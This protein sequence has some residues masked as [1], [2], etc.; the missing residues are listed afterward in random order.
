MT[1]NDN[2]LQT[3]LSYAAKGWPVFPVNS[4]KLP[5][6]KDWER[7]ASTDPDQIKKWYSTLMIGGCNFGFTPG[8]AGILVVDID[9]NKKDKEGNEVS[10]EKNWDEFQTKHGK[11][12]TPYRVKT[13]SGGLHL[14]FKAENL[15]SK[16]AFLP[17]VDVKS[18]GGYV[19]IPGSRNA[20]GE[21][22]IVEAGDPAPLPESFRKEYGRHRAATL[23]EK[24]TV[25]YMPKLTLDS[26][27]KLERAADVM[28]QWPEAAEGERNEQLYRMM[29]EVCKCGVSMAKAKELYVAK[30]LD[31]IG[32]DADSYEVLAT[33]KSAYGDLS[34]LGVNSEEMRSADVMLLD[35]LPPLPGEE[36]AA[37]PYSDN[38]GIDWA[39]LAAKE[40]PA[41]RWFIENWL[42]A[43]EGYTV[44]FS[45]RGGSGKS[46]LVL[47][48][49]RSL[50][51]GTEFLGKPVL[52]G[53]RVMY[54]SCEDSEE[55]IAR[56]I[57]MGQRD[58]ERVPQGVLRVW[59]RAGRD[60]LLV[61]PTKTGIL[62]EGPF[63]KELLA[64]GREF[65]G[66]QGGV[67]VLDTLAD[68][69]A[70]NEN[71]RTQVSQFVKRFL[72]KLGQD[73][74]VTIIVL[75]HP[76]KGAAKSGQGYSGSSAWEGAFRCRWELNAVTEGVDTGALELVLAKSNQ[77]KAGEK[78]MI[79]ITRGRF[80]VVEAA[81]YDDS[82]REDIK[83]NI[84]EAYS[85]KR[86]Y[87]L[88][89]IAKR[90]IANMEVRNP[91]TGESIPG[92]VVYQIVKR[93]IEAGEV[94]ECRIGGYAGLRLVK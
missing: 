66:T 24:A 39:D 27:D 10:G 43:D 17:A 5:A 92:T 15:R 12:E 93:L 58:G 62:Q 49:M 75:A 87:G 94:E 73:L 55:E 57:Q 14:Y 42:S 38:G 16:N 90:P 1:N 61:T 60:N 67:L 65:F 30:G 52:R 29:R 81:A 54:I 48:L 68:M 37:C 45:G 71:D 63:M 34:D 89:N 72:N 26:P 50:A 7:N 91:V 21:Y 56:R 80:G 84:G 70:G 11:C 44:L 86:M 18:C 6:I 25:N 41:R 22:S 79:S 85:N 47:D 51:T 59:S 69:F 19:V 20:K 33:I 9:C 13:P 4:N 23:V 74:G 35:E 76:A 83:W 28:E 3:A 82:I 64:R 53:S 31:K 78:I 8:R 2:R 88:S 36:K 40:V 46:L 77:V 32:L